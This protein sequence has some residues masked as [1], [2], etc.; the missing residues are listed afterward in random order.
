MILLNDASLIGAH[1]DKGLSEHDVYVILHKM[2]TLKAARN[3]T[4]M[5]VFGNLRNGQTD[6]ACFMSSRTFNLNNLR[7]SFADAFNYQGVVFGFDQG[8]ASNYHYKAYAANANQMLLYYARVAG[9]F[10]KQFTA[11][12]PIPH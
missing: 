4:A 11:W 9:D 3:V 7:K 10:D 8:P 12:I 6:R 5:M 1:L 2:D